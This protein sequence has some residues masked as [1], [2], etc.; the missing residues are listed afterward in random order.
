MAEFY[1]EEIP[2]TYHGI[3]FGNA[4]PIGGPIPNW[5][6]AEEGEDPIIG[7][8]QMLH[9]ELSR[10]FGRV[11]TPESATIVVPF[12]LYANYFTKLEAG[13]DTEEDRAVISAFFQR[14]N[15]DIVLIA[16]PVPEVIPDPEIIPEEEIT[17]NTED[18]S[19]QSRMSVQAEEQPVVEKKLK[20]RSKTS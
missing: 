20:P 10:S 12:D 13:T 15:P 2:L 6:F 14:Q 9:Y 3:K 4:N 1:I 5:N 18:Q 7:M 17:E 16:K 19:P 11:R 8:G